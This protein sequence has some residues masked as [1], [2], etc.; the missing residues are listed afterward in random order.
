[1]AA[2]INAK[3]AARCVAFSPQGVRFVHHHH[4]AHGTQL[5][6]GSPVNGTSAM[7]S[8]LMSGP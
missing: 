6:K 3:E 1:M 2:G 7:S 8:E 5:L 4:A